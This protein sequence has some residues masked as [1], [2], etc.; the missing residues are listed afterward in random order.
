MPPRSAEGHRATS[1]RPIP[2]ATY[3]ALAAAF[4]NLPLEIYQ[5]L[6]N[7]IQYQPYY[8]EMKGPLAVLNPR[9][10]R[11]GHRRSAGRHMSSK[12]ESPRSMFWGQAVVDVPTVMTW[13]G[14][15]TPA[16]AYDVLAVAGLQPQFYAADETTALS[17]GNAAT[18]PYLG[19]DHA[20]L[21]ASVTPPEAST[22]QTVY[23]DPTWKFDDFQAGLPGLLDSSSPNYVPFATDGT[24]GSYNPVHQHD[25]RSE[26]GGLYRRGERNGRGVLRGAGPQLPGRQ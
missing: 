12:W 22:A 16:S 2:T 21:Q 14:V 5:Y 23:L 15:K 19:F 6:V 9:R 24:A 7:T 1:T 10:Q 11:L 8:G 25:H 4:Y 20:W 3:T 13:L 26:A 18:A 17:T